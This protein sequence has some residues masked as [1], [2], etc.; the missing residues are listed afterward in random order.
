MLV[1]RLPSIKGKGRIA[2]VKER[3]K[4]QGNITVTFDEF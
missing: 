4:N 3:E 1:H 2:S